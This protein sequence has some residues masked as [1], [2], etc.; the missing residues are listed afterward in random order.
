VSGNIWRCKALNWFEG[1]LLDPAEAE[2]TGGRPI[3]ALLTLY[4]AVEKALKTVYNGK[5]ER[6]QR[7]HD[8]IELFRDHD[9][10]PF[11]ASAYTCYRGIK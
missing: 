9:F 1:M 7:A 10:E 3:W 5:H 4:Q 11:E 8:L 2:L 6:F